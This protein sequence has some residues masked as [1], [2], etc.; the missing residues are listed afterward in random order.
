MFKTYTIPTISKLLCGTREFEKDCP[1]RVDDTELILGEI[2]DTYGRIQKQLE[3]DPSTPQADIDEQPR[4]ADQ[5][6]KRLN[7]LH[8]KYPILNGDYIY[9]LS[10]FI[11]E[12]A[13]WINKYEWR[14]LDIREKY[15]C[16]RSHY[17]T[18][19]E[20]QTLPY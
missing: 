18:I 6:V 15:V 17:I 14:Q 2:T 3:K 9:T 10:L 1:R 13:N 7:E 20:L 8:G 16:T 19:Y 11:E 4:R 5:A 12:P